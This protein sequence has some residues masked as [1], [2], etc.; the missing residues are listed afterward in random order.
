MVMS[1]NLLTNEA[2]LLKKMNP[3]GAAARRA[4]RIDAGH[5]PGKLDPDDP[6]ASLDGEA[7]AGEVPV[8]VLPVE[9]LT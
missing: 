6:V 7:D 8:E 4:L 3:F 9:A 2:F 5:A 1:A